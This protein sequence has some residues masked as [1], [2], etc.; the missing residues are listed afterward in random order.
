MERGEEARQP[1][2]SWREREEMERVSGRMMTE[3]EEAV[4]G[5]VGGLGSGEEE[6]ESESSRGGGER[7]EEEEEEEGRTESP[8]DSEA[9]EVVEEE[10]EDERRLEDIME[11]GEEGERDTHVDQG[12]SGDGAE[13]EGE[14]EPVTV[15]DNYNLVL[16]EIQSHGGQDS[17]RRAKVR[18]GDMGMPHIGAFGSEPAS[19]LLNRASEEEPS[20]LG[21]QTRESFMEWNEDYDVDSLERCRRGNVGPSKNPIIVEIV[22]NAPQLG[23]T[24]TGGVDTPSPGVIITH[25]KE[26]GAAGNDG[27]LQVAGRQPHP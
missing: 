26:G 11:E 6:E 9:H 27:F 21:M 24:I 20:M 23:L 7:E 10:E 5:E 25:V 14:L 4:E 8:P 2:G 18:E 1:A 15:Q 12:D 19:D 17:L 22:K 13:E 16:Y 3:P